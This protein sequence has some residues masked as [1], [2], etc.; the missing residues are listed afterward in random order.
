MSLHRVIYVSD[1]A[2]IAATSLLTL[3]DILGASERNNRRDHITGVLILHSG[4]FLQWVEGA[5]LDLDRLMARISRDPRHKNLVVLSDLP[6]TERSFPDWSMVQVQA[7][8]PLVGKL[9]ATLTPKDADDVERLMR[10]AVLAR[11]AH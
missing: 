9:S 6:I 2:E 11:A 5:R 10:S 1:A 8:P 7:D 4:K 3:V